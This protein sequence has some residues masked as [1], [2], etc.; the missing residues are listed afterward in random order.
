MFKDI[1]K[2]QTIERAMQNLK[3]KGAATVYAAKF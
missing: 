3:Q 2:E 1:N